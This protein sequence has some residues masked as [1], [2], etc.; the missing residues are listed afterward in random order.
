[1][2]ILETERLLLRPFGEDD[3]DNL[4]AL[5]AELGGLGTP[6]ARPRSRTET[7]RHLHKTL[8]HWRDHGFGLFALAAREDGRL[9]GHCGVAYLHELPD[10]ELSYALATRY[11][12]RGLATEA[13]TAV[14]RH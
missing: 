8:E 11:H 9:A 7:Q 5:Q 10:A 2:T 1:M 6:G 12:G 4:A 13:V 3:L 14:L